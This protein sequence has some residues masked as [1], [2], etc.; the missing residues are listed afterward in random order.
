MSVEVLSVSAMTGSAGQG[1]TP[2]KLQSL[3]PFSPP[4]HLGKG[5][6]SDARSRLIEGQ[7]SSAGVRGAGRRRRCPYAT[8]CH[9]M[10]RTRARHP[11]RTVPPRS[12]ATVATL[13]FH[14]AIRQHTVLFPSPLSLEMSEGAFPVVWRT[15]E[16]LTGDHRRTASGTRPLTHCRSAASALR[17]RF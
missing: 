8:R 4:N 11:G 13:E 1:Q 10:P 14:S 6:L 2:K 3:V 17:C 5:R 9:T 15:R 16:S 7:E 12:S